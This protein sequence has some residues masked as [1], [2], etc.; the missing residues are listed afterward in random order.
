MEQACKKKLESPFTEKELK[1]LHNKGIDFVNGSFSCS[2]CQ[3]GLKKHDLYPHLQ[4]KRHEKKLAL[5][6]KIKKEHQLEKRRVEK[7]KKQEMK[8]TLAVKNE[9]ISRE[10]ILKKEFENGKMEL[11]CSLC[12]VVIISE[13][14]INVHLSGQLHK[15]TYERYSK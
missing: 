5:N 7:S 3:I 1:K 11:V 6:D 4:G 9:I 15:A 2:I 13:K 12:D 8:E 14:T 10:F